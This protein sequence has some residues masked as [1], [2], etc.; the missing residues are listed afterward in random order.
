MSIFIVYSLLVVYCCFWFKWMS[1]ECKVNYFFIFLLIGFFFNV[2][3][4]FF[5]FFVFVFEFI[6]FIFV[7][8]LFCKRVVWSS[9]ELFWS[10][11]IFIKLWGGIN[12][13]RVFDGEYMFIIL[14]S[15]FVIFILLGFLD[16][17]KFWNFLYVKVLMW[18]FFIWLLWDMRRVLFGFGRLL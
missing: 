2:R 15:F 4:D 8:I 3:G 10:W 12:I 5:L 6:F 18:M 14:Y 9:L 17:M 1:M 13:G 11:S 7:F 16:W